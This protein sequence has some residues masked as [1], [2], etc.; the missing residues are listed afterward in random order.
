MAAPEVTME[1]KVIEFNV[2][3]TSW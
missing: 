1:R 3:F 2:R